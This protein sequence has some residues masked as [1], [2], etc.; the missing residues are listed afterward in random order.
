MHF[1]LH[2]WRQ[3][4]TLA[5]GGFKTYKVQDVSP[6]NSFLEMLDVLNLKLESSGRRAYSL[7]S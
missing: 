4:D 1:T 6:D 2:I 7:R 3:K 5:R